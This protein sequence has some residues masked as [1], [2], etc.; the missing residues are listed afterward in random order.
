[1]VETSLTDLRYTVRDWRAAR[2]A[3]TA[4][5]GR[6]TMTT[7]GTDTS[8]DQIR[9]HAQHS[10]IPQLGYHAVGGVG[11]DGNREGYGI[12]N[13]SGLALMLVVRGSCVDSIRGL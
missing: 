10:M 13:E 7:Q 3:L 4:S 1:M 12:T 5:R 11:G 9:G 2:L 8:M 6:K